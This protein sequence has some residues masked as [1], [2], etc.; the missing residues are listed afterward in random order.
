MHGRESTPWSAAPV[1]EALVARDC[2]AAPLDTAEDLCGRALTTPASARGRPLHRQVH[3]RHRR[4]LDCDARPHGP[5]L[6]AVALSSRRAIYI[7]REAIR[8]GRHRPGLRIERHWIVLIEDVFE[9]AHE[10][11]VK[12]IETNKQARPRRGRARPAPAR[13]ENDVAYL[14][15]RLLAINRRG[16]G[17]TRNSRLQ[18]AVVLSPD[19]ALL[20]D[21]FRIAHQE[22]LAPCQL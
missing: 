16:G 11:Y 20:V 1:R 18:R 17:P 12:P 4:G 2:L 19:R 14:H 13:R 10:R 15:R 7:A 5:S 21:G 6:S 22:Q 9:R 3:G 8:R